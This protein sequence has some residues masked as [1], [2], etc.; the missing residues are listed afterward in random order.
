MIRFSCNTYLIPHTVHV[1]PHPLPHNCPFLPLPQRLQRHSL[2][3]FLVEYHMQ[4]GK[5]NTS[6]RDF[7]TAFS[8]RIWI[9]LKLD[10]IVLGKYATNNNNTLASNFIYSFLF[11]KTFVSLFLYCSRS[12]SRYTQHDILRRCQ[13]FNLAWM[14]RLF[15]I[16]M[17]FAMVRDADKVQNTTRKIS[18]SPKTRYHIYT[19]DSRIAHYVHAK[20]Y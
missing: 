8:R 7:G 9:L 13:K 19:F 2:N 18:A 17:A 11:E 20:F 15:D 5:T 14:C 6:A 12:H 3:G 1:H 10:D 16:R 4:T